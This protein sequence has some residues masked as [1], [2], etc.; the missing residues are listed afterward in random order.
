MKEPTRKTNADALKYATEQIFCYGWYRTRISK[1]MYIGKTTMGYKRL[2]SH[3]IVGRGI[4][5]EPLD[6]IHYWH[7]TPYTVEGATKEFIASVYTIEME[8]LEKDLIQHH[9]P[10]LNCNEM[11]MHRVRLICGYCK[12]EYP[13]N[14]SWQKFCSKKCQEKSWNSAPKEDKMVMKICGYCHEQFSIHY[15][16]LGLANS[17]LC[18]NCRGGEYD[19]ETY[20]LIPLVNP[21]NQ[22]ETPK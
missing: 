21:V 22:N 16:H 7:P 17:M 1:Y 12:K 14:R 3:N 20:Q 4:E 5:F 10:E 19:V 9:Q 13:A 6:E 11:G 2:T 8:G 15:V 18:A